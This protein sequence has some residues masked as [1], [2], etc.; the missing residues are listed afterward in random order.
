M[1]AFYSFREFKFFGISEV[2]SCISDEENDWKYY[3]ILELQIHQNKGRYQYLPAFLSIST[4][5]QHRFTPKAYEE[6]ESVVKQCITTPYEWLRELSKVY[7][8]E[9]MIYCKMSKSYCIVVY[10]YPT[11]E[12]P[13][14]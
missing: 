6:C 9:L 11:D 2:M 10:E 5:Y 12:D 1:S 7:N 3:Q 4:K 13:F 14:C 8:R